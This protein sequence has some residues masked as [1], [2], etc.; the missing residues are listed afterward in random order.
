MDAAFF[1]TL[2]K[3]ISHYT[4]YYYCVSDPVT[5][6]L[7]LLAVLAAGLEEQYWLAITSNVRWFAM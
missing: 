1:F 5:S 6:G 2:S 7:K 4:N 3:L